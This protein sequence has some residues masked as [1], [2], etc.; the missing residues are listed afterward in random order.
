[1]FYSPQGFFNIKD[2][3]QFSD[4]L[5][6]LFGQY[7]Y[8]LQGAHAA[9]QM[10]TFGRNLTFMWDSDF[11]ESFEKNARSNNDKITLWRKAVHYWAARHCINLTGD[12]VE[13]GV[14]CV[15]RSG[16]LVELA[17][18]NFLIKLVDALCHSS[19]VMI[20]VISTDSIAVPMAISC[21]LCRSPEPAKDSRMATMC[22]S[23][24]SI[25]VFKV[26][27]LLCRL[28]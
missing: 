14:D 17:A 28:S 10:I 16:V 23:M 6:G 22:A 24:R 12:F 5:K 1:M 21:L 9:D 19:N 27:I 2:T 4:L 15:A 13:C 11:T 26:S 18:L 25:L 20:P 7:L 3:N 8:G